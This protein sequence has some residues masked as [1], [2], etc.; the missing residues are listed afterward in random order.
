MSTIRLCFF[1][2]L[3]HW[4]LL[5][6]AAEPQLNEPLKDHRDHVIRNNPAIKFL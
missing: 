3:C 1:I 5:A 6:I 4:H 2:L